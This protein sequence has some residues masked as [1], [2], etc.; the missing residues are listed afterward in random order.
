MTAGHVPLDVNL[1]GTA[2]TVNDSCPHDHATVAIAMLGRVLDFRCDCHA[3]HCARPSTRQPP[4]RQP[5]N[6]S[7]RQP[8]NR[9]CAE[10]RQPAMYTLYVDV[11]DS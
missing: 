3:P 6:P 4:T 7:T 5:V 10:T 1:H 9:M 8:V 2:T 11:I